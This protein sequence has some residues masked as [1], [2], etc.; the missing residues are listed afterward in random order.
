MWFPAKVYCLLVNAVKPAE[1][2]VDTIRSLI[3]TILSGKDEAGG[4]G[5]CWFW[6]RQL[7]AIQWHWSF[8]STRNQYVYT[9]V[10]HVSEM[11]SRIN[12]TWVTSVPCWPHL[13]SITLALNKWAASPCAAPYSH[14][15]P[16]NRTAKEKIYKICAADAFW[17]PSILSVL[18]SQIC[19]RCNI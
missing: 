16:G 19:N 4:E 1:G 13:F 14:V 18:N 9:H 11:W 5:H 15:H 3:I 6:L 2:R 12:P 7:W 10:S 17:C 8:L